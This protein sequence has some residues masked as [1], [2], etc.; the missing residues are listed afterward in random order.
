MV[1]MVR[2]C[3]SP[4]FWIILLSMGSI[5]PATKSEYTALIKRFPAYAGLAKDL[6]TKARLT[7]K[8][9][10]IMG[11]GLGYLAS[12][13]DLIPGFIPA[14]GQLDDLLVI[15]VCLRQ[16]IEEHDEDKVEEMLSARN[17]ARTQIDYDIELVK[18]TMKAIVKKTA[19]VAWN[20]MSRIGKAAIGKIKSV[21][22]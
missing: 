22:D 5:L 15:L 17:L 16:V 3:Q 10:V 1:I 20:G 12:P 11:A 2:I 13:I 7:S 19:S 4:S 18:E 21:T 9:K 6:I 8:Q 14:L